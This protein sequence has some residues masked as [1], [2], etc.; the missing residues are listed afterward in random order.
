MVGPNSANDAPLHLIRSAR[1]VRLLLLLLL[2]LPVNTANVVLI[3]ANV[4]TPITG[5]K[6]KVRF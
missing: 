5:Q 3:V 1:R 4:A 2:L 6:C